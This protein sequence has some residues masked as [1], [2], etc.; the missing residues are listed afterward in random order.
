[1][2]QDKLL[3]LVGLAQR[4]GKIASGEFSTEKSVKEGKAYCVIVALDASENTKKNFT[5]M[6]NYYHIPIYFYGDKETIGK[7]IG[8]EFRA[9]I[10]I[11]DEGFAKSVVRQI[12]VLSSK[13]EI[14]P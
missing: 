10:A 4:A 3:S 2:K 7:A 11:N 8:K 6:C 13:G 9:S 5:N 14:N 1:M 12:T